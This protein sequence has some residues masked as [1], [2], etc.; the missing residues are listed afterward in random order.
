MNHTKVLSG[1]LRICVNQLGISRIMSF[2][3]NVKIN[4][5][6]AVAIKFPTSVEAATEKK[7]KL[8]SLSRSMVCGNGT[9]KRI[10]NI[11]I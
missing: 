3:N 10:I 6:V 4:A 7:I 11:T 9:H 1:I 8:I 5:C 2:V